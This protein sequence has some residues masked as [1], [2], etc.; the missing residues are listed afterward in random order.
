MEDLY[1]ASGYG[2]RRVGY[3][4]RPAVLV[5]DLQNAVTSPR[6]PMGRSP[7]VHAAVESTARLLPAA[8]NA[9]APVVF[10]TTSFKPD[11]SDR[12]P[13]KI[14]AIDDWIDGTWEAEVDE[15]LWQE[16][17]TYVCKKVPSI[18]FGT[19]VPSFLTLH[20][21]DTVI[22]TGANTSGCIRASAIDSF[23]H[24]FRTIVPRECVGDQGR[25]PHEANLLDIDRRYVDVVALDEVLDYLETVRGLATM[26]S[27]FEKGASVGA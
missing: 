11:L 4:E 19:G 2:E 26:S 7:L 27:N 12:P 5:V 20:R 24:G 9:G 3:G 15:R 1:T 6:A 14:S 8:R 25:E 18:F 21:V 16:G 10:C 13:W 23:S 22:L 17:D